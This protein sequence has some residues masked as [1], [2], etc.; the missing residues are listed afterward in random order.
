MRKIEAKNAA[1]N[2]RNNQVALVKCTSV[3]FLSSLVFLLAFAGKLLT[4][5]FFTFFFNYKTRSPHTKNKINV[6]DVKAQKNKKNQIEI[7]LK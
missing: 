3:L 6:F 2:L 4:F 5:L 7:L 1:K